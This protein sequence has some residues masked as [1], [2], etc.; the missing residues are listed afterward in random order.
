M[1]EKYL[2]DLAPV[3][4]SLQEIIYLQI[5][6]FS[7]FGE[8]EHLK[9]ELSKY[10]DVPMLQVQ[11]DRIAELENERDALMAEVEA[12]RKLESFA[13]HLVT[14]LNSAE[15][16][17]KCDDRATKMHLENFIAYTEDAL[18]DLDQARAGK[19]KSHE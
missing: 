19:E 9:Y 17:V 18:Q 1:N 8:N 2:L 5:Y 11:A 14:A 3:D 13:A 10:Y 12:I 6:A 15:V 16:H 4:M 7:L